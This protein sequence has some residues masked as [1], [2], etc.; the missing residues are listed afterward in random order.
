MKIS[1]DQTLQQGILAHKEGKLKEAE[2]LYKYI[3]KTHPKHPHANHNL[4][5]IAVTM[6]QLRSAIHLFRSILDDNPQI[7]QFWISYIDIL[8]K[9]REYKE[10]ETALKI[11]ILMRLLINLN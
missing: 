10:A 4:G 11:I 5:L 7:E 3:L 9:E 6:N 2:L 8:I 1:V